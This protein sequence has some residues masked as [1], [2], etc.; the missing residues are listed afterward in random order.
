[1]FQKFALSLLIIHIFDIPIFYI[2][3][4]LQHPEW[5]LSDSEDKNCLGV[6]KLWEHQFCPHPQKPKTEDGVG[7][8][9]RLA[10]AQVSNESADS[11][12]SPKRLSKSEH[13]IL[14]EIFRKIG[15]KENTKEVSW[16]SLVKCLTLFY[17]KFS[18]IVNGNNVERVS[19][20]YS[21][22]CR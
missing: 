9:N 8:S 16:L 5:R 21:I 12:K 6:R 1:M 13:N 3:L 22:N 10:A 2:L 20:V 15:S 4:E 17:S 18:R 19:F 7:D 14:S 11:V